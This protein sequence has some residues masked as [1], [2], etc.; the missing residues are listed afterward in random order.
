MKYSV[1]WVYR[2]IGLEAKRFLFCE[3]KQ[4]FGLNNGKE[5]QLLMLRL[6]P[7]SSTF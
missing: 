5:R 6:F 2:S 3:A 1:V 7:V 4:A